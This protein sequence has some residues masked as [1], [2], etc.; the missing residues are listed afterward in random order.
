MRTCHDGPWASG[1]VS[2]LVTGTVF[3]IAERQSLSLAGSIPVR[4]RHS[5]AGLPMSRP[6]TARAANRCAARRPRLAEADVVLGRALVK[7]H[8]RPGAGAGPRAARSSRSR[9]PTT[10]SQ[11]SGERGEPATGHQCDR[12]RGAHEPRPGPA[13]PAADRRGGRRLA[14]RPTSSSIW[15][16]VG[17]PAA[18]AVPWPRWPQ[19]YRRRRPCTSSTTT[20]PRC[21][22][23][24]WPWPPASE[25]VVSRGELV[26]IGD[27]FR[28]P[29]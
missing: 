18:V 23:S 22:W 9:S 7:S 5:F 8:C 29:S 4:L 3:K 13:V 19:R 12:C 15:R 6:A 28:C 14:A 2:G 16:P 24:R 21:C 1:G 27:G 17:G 26:E 10:R 25:I 11:P 20:P